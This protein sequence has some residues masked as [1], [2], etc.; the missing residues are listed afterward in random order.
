MR[1]EWNL[2]QES[3][4]GGNKVLH[5]LVE[6]GSNIIKRSWGL[7]GKKQQDMEKEVQGKNI[8]KANETSPHEQACIE[9]EAIVTRKIKEGYRA[10]GDTEAQAESKVFQFY[11]LPENF[12]P[13]KPINN[14]PGDVTITDGGKGYFAERKYNG[15]NLLMV[16]DLEGNKC[17]YTRGIKE[18]TDIVADIIPIQNINSIPT[19][20]G[21]I[22]SYEFVYFD[23]NGLEV[24]KMLRGIVNERTTREKAAQRFDDLRAAGGAFTTIVFDI[25]FWDGKDITGLDYDQRRGIMYDAYFSSHPEFQPICTYVLSPEVISF[26][27]ENGWEGFILRK[28]RGK[29][30]HVEY[31]M[32]G[33]PY[34]KGAWKFKFE[35]T[36][37]YFIYEAKTGDSGRLKGKLAQFHLGKYDGAGK[38]ID[39]GWAGPGNI[40]TDELDD[41]AKL[42]EV[43][44]DDMIARQAYPTTYLTVEVKYQSKQVDSNALEFPV[45]REIRLDKPPRNCLIDD[46]AEVA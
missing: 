8:G 16:T 40:P 46:I 27:I 26:A 6:D 18:I 43:D 35:W 33:K 32:N 31:T 7:E 38:V 5:I 15:V 22:V 24:P 42:L 11:P 14:A 9:A 12:A 10:V 19:K 1:K 2:I 3:R 29:E 37:D 21:S 30:S 4:L 44:Q 41:L 36:E 25:L 17:T 39:C 13:S 34:R 20:P 23:K 28:L 45:I